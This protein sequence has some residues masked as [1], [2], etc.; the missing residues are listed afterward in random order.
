MAF[1]QKILS[2]FWPKLSEEDEN[3]I[4]S[5]IE[6]FDLAVNQMEG[7]YISLKDISEFNDKWKPTYTEILSTR[8]SK[9]SSVYPATQKFFQDFNHLNDTFVGMNATFLDLRSKQLDILLSDIDGKSLDKQQRNVVLSDEQRTLVLAGAGS[10]KTLTISG[11][12]KY[13]CQECHV[14]PEDIL[15]IAFT[16]KSAEEM[17]ERILGRLGISVEA[18]TFHKLGLDIITASDG[19]RPDV[20]DNLLD[21]VRSYFE[22]DLVKNPKSVRN[23]IEFF[24]N[25]L[26]IPAD[27]EQFDSL[28]ALYEHEKTADFKTLR[29]KYN[30]SQWVERTADE[31]KK[32]RRTLN[33]EQVKSMEEVMI[34][35]YLFLNGVNYEYERLYP[36]ESDDPKRK[37]Y[38]PDFYLPDYDIYIE[39][40]GITKDERVPWLSKIE[41]K[42]Y[43]EEMS[44]K[45]EFHKANG[46]TLLETYSYLSSEGILQEYL[47]DLLKKHGVKFHEPDFRDIFEKVYEKQSDRYFLDFINLCCTF[48]TLFKSKG[49]K[50]ENL[51]SLNSSAG[52]F[53]KSFFQKR[54]EL[55]KQILQPIL[56]A[57]E[58]NLRKNKAVDFAD[59]INHATEL[60]KNGF[61]VH[62][63]K[64]VIVDEYQDISFARHQLVKAILDQ[65]EAK[66]L[67]VGDDWQSIYRF[68]GSDITLFTRFQDYFGSSAIFRLEQTYRNAQQLIDEAG[69]FVMKN[70][71]QMSK[72]LKSPK[73]LERPITFVC[74]DASPVYE[75]C[76]ILNEIIS[77]F[78]PQASIMLLGRTNSDRELISD[79]NFFK[80]GKNDS[81]RYNLSPETPISFM[82]VHKA[83]GLEAD[84]VV[85]LNFQNKT[86][87]FPNKI[88]DDPV[89]QLVLTAPEQYP[90]AEERRL[91][92]VAITRTRNRI[93]ILT[94]SN[95]PS[96]F[97]DEFKQS[98]SVK[99]IS[100][101]NKAV[102]QV[103]CPRCKTG[104]LLQKRV[105]NNYFVGCSNYP[106]CDYTVRDTSILTDK[107]ICPECGGFLIRRKGKFGLFYGCT[108]YPFCEYTEQTEQANNSKRSK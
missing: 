79:A 74:Y 66:L 85:L 76:N 94:D 40:F 81:I 96:E 68:A 103:N 108:N 84:N 4:K 89:L 18:T 93:F 55:F 104:V 28:G 62:P 100:T 52:L 35:N 97:F 41:E 95:C 38:R 47:E 26:Y 58:E 23:L 12:V 44:W 78:G 67:C 31:R 92:Y 30:Q 105:S 49:Y 107:R 83:K 87:G 60:V 3:N 61:Q 73:N 10:G 36:F 77:E 102:D 11:K 19:K 21:F 101:A 16:K 2:L 9:K 71:D 98:A 82:T 7:C 57:Y 64:Y 72:K 86:L 88:T 48:I 32:I 91:L 63:Y 99:V 39:H 54:T 46:T 80:I 6:T 106:K 14:V 43:L 56:F 90:Y 15:L 42:K 1:F 34:A 25:Y 59:M 24:A 13:L 37:A 22:N 45:R 69:R 65:T 27:M 53:Q 75:L 29:S 20:Q 33:D 70:P 17:T 5:K 51:N 50:T 8:I